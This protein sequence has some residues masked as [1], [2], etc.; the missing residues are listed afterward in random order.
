MTK[1]C[2]QAVHKASGLG[3]SEG[4]P[5]PREE[6][7]A[8]LPCGARQRDGVLPLRVLPVVVVLGHVVVADV[9][10]VDDFAPHVVFA[11]GVQGRGGD[12]GVVYTQ[13]GADMVLVLKES[14]EMVAGEA[15]LEGDICICKVLYANGIGKNPV[16]WCVLL[17]ITMQVFH[18]I[19]RKHIVVV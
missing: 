14:E 4:E 16:C 17:H 8:L 6:R 5:V 2:K 3:G 9:A 19:G 13:A 18:R 7:Y 12:L 1:A 11:D 15:Y 10:A